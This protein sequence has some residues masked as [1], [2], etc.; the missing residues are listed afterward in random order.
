MK[1]ISLFFILS[2][3]A[4]TLS[5]C[6]TPAEMRQRAPELEF[7]S[8]FPSKTVAICIADRWENLSWVGGTI[9]VNMRP[10]NDGYTVSWRNEAWGHTGLLVDIKDT[11]DGSLT[12]YFKNMVLGEGTFDQVVIDCQD[13]KKITIEPNTKGNT[14]NKP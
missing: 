6:A 2:L 1:K 7:K 3:I 9:P 10:T 11:T 13:P 14:I 12:R 4:S 8:T 5:A